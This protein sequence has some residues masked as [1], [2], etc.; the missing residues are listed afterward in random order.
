MPNTNEVKGVL[1]V[2]PAE[3]IDVGVERFSDV[4]L[5]A[6]GKVV[7]AQPVA[8]ALVTVSLH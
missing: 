4:L 3:I 7:D 2:C 5:F 8:V 1:L 6:T